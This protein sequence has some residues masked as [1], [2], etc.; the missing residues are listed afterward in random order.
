MF[1]KGAA[2]SISAFLT[3]LPITTPKVLQ[4]NTPDLII[5]VNR[6]LIS[7]ISVN[8]FVSKGIPCFRFFSCY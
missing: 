7:F 2:R 5:L 4:R 1:S 3:K 8:I 6:V